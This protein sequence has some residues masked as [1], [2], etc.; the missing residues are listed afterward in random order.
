MKSQPCDLIGKNS[1]VFVEPID[2]KI[3]SVSILN[4]QII[5]RFDF[6]K[7]TLLCCVFDSNLGG[8]CVHA[9]D[10]QPGP[11]VLKMALVVS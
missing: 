4:V 5:I 10:R 7:V 3:P 1:I 8:A 6:L 9:V 11:S 2:V